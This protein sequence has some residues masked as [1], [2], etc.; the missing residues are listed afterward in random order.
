MSVLA[1]FMWTSDLCMVPLGRH[2]KKCAE[3]FEIGETYRL[4]AVSDRSWKSHRHYFAC[5]YEG[6]MNLG[7][8]Y[9]MEPWAAT[10]E[11][12]RKYALIKTGWYNSQTWTCGSRAEAGRTSV[13]IRSA[14]SEYSI[15]VP[16]GTTVVRYTAKSQA[17]PAMKAKDFQKSK[18]DV[19]TFIEGLIGLEAGELARQVPKDAPTGEGK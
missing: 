18:D 7:E 9:G 16:I 10:S 17:G 15:I 11:H 8:A 4:E 1:V 3:A 12:L 13:A 6:W 2:R 5:V 19:L 14:V